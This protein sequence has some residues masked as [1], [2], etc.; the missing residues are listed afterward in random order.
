MNFDEL[1]RSTALTAITELIDDSDDL[2][3]DDFA[4]YAQIVM[5]N[6]TDATLKSLAHDE[7]TLDKIYDLMIGYCDAMN[8]SH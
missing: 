2:N 8:I 6:S 3:D 5:L 1:M 4:D 7:A